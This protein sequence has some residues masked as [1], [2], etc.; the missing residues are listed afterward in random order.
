MKLEF[1]TKVVAVAN[2]TAQLLIAD[3]SESNSRSELLGFT[4]PQPTLRMYIERAT[5]IVEGAERYLGNGQ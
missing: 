4:V 2:I 3:S 1:Q 5:A